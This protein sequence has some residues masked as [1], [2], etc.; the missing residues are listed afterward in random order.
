V[1]RFIE[2]IKL[3]KQNLNNTIQFSYFW[4][5]L[6]KDINEINENLNILRLNLLKKLIKQ[7]QI[8]NIDLKN[9]NVTV[10]CKLHIKQPRG[11]YTQEIILINENI[12]K[13]CS[14][15]E[16]ESEIDKLELKF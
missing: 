5:N 11:I 4:E 9:Y 6:N 13:T 14:Q 12:N 10:I 15:K 8:K 7:K 2:N 1:S 16:I 3:W